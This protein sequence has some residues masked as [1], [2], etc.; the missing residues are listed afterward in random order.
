MEVV[1]RCKNDVCVGA[2]FVNC[3]KL[4]FVCV[5]H[6]KQKILSKS[7]KQLAYIVCIGELSLAMGKICRTVQSKARSLPI[8]E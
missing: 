7:V 8:Q 1:P 2:L 6:L 3:T 4:Y 5:L